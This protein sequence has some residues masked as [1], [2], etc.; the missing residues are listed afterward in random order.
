MELATG[1]LIERE[2]MGEEPKVKTSHYTAWLAETQSITG[3]DEITEWPQQWRR[4]K[5]EADKAAALREAKNGA[6][7]PTGFALVS[8]RSI[9]FR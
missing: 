4:V 3:P 8:K 6:K 9:R 5:V 7:L 2:A 1:L